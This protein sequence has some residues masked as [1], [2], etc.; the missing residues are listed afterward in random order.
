MKSYTVKPGDCLSTIAARHGFSRW[1]DVYEHGANAELRQRR[2][3]PNVLHPGDVVMV[4]ALRERTEAAATGQRHHFVYKPPRRKLRIQLLDDA[5]LPLADLLFAADDGSRLH[6]GQTD[7][8][9]FAEVELRA[10]VRDLVVHVLGWE[11]HFAVGRLNP[12]VET[13]DDKGISGCQARLKGLG[14]DP[15]VIDGVLGTRTRA[16]L[17]SFQREHDLAITGEADAETRAKL[18]EI[19]RC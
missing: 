16:A 9:G 14:F 2:P 4:P 8:E 3:D 1:Q 7:G 15:G 12:E 17:V 5:G 13:T 11:R 18:K 10:E 6:S 19:F